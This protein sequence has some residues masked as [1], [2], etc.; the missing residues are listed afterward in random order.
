MHHRV[1][2]LKDQGMPVLFRVSITRPSDIDGVAAVCQ[3]LKSRTLPLPVLTGE[4]QTG[5]HFGT[6]SKITS[7]VCQD[8]LQTKKLTYLLYSLKKPT[9]HDIDKQAIH[10]YNFV[11]NWLHAI[12]DQPRK[13]FNDVATELWRLL[14]ISHFS[15][16]VAVCSQLANKHS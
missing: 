9:A 14:D 1:N 10:L 7:I 5:I 6:I 11:Q 4:L 3:S 15:K 13:V 8:F 2:L 16:E 12:F